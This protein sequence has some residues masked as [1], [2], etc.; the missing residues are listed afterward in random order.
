MTMRYY[1]SITVAG[2]CLLL[3]P[4]MAHALQPGTYRCSSYNVSGGGGSC[5]N[6]QPHSHLWE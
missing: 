2:L 3:T 1:R 4:G 6:F 5:R